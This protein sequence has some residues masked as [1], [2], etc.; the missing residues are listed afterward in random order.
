MGKDK[1]RASVLAMFNLKLLWEPKRSSSWRKEGML[2][3]G[4][5]TYSSRSSANRESLQWAEGVGIPCMDLL[6]RIAWARCSIVI[7][8][9]R[10]DRGQSCLV[11]LLIS[12]VSECTPLAVTF[13]EG[14]K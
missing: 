6:W 4:C 9:R 11:P 3:C 10:G 8:K 1:F 14:L 5:V 2:M 12:N 13:A 7:A